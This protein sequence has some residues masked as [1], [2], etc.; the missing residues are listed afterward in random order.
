MEGEGWADPHAAA[1]AHA[2]PGVAAEL[3]AAFGVR[4][5]EAPHEEALL[6]GWTHP[7]ERVEEVVRAGGES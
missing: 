4:A 5:F 7:G 6:E 1:A 3:G 2:L